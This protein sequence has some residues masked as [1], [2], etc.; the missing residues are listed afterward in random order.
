VILETLEI[1]I[2]P[3]FLKAVHIQPTEKINRAAVSTK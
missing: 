1:S 2:G 3:G